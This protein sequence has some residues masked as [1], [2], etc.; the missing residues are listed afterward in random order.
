VKKLIVA[1]LCLCLLALCACG[2]GEPEEITV[3]ATT[4]AIPT[5]TE[6]P[7]TL[8]IEYPANYRD[9]PEAYKPVLNEFYY[10]AQNGS[11]QTGDIYVLEPWFFEMDDL[12]YAVQDINGDGV[13][14]LL[15]LTKG[16]YSGFAAEENPFILT[17]FTLTNDRPVHL[18]YY[19]RRERAQ[20]AADGII[21][22]VA[23]LGGSYSGLRSFQLETGASELTQLTE[24]HR[25]SGNFYKGTYGEQ[26]MPEDEFNRLYELYSNPPNPMQLTFIPIEQ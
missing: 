1:V 17:L 3:P 15:L 9:A 22:F 13:P 6:A 19:W 8:P 7:T 2:W 23:G 20:L 26:S 10:Q 21:Y 25:E 24:Y 12:G 11:S 16:E 14:E 5:T 4:T 18:A